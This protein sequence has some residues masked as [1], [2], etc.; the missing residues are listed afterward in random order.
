[1]KQAYLNK[2]EYNKILEILSSYCKTYVGKEIVENLL[3]SNNKKEVQNLLEETNQAVN[4]TYRISTPPV[5]EISNIDESLIILNDYGT[6]SIKS[7][8]DIAK[9]LKISQEL[10]DYFYTDIIDTSSFT[11]LEQ[12]F[13]NLYTNKNIVDKI[14]KIIID[15]NTI[16][17]D[18]SSNLKTIRKKQ[19]NLEQD[20]KDKLNSFIHSS[21]YSK[22]V[23]E[24]IITIRNDRYVIPIKEEYRSM[25]KG[26]IHDVSSSGSTVFIEPITVMKLII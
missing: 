22:Y 8:L 17:D 14:F 13:S 6:L 16:S 26:F 11:S 5:S 15:E 12:Y 19:R 7:I 21:N 2:L 18:A 10:K 25:V 9:I 4:L 23:Q 3:P 1:M 20:I 24:N